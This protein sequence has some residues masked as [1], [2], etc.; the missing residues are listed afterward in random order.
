MTTTNHVIDSLSLNLA[1]ASILDSY[2]KGMGKT[3]DLE[4]GWKLSNEI[5]I[6]DF[7]HDSGA[8]EL[9]FHLLNE[10]LSIQ[11]YAHCIALLTVELNKSK[12]SAEYLQHVSKGRLSLKHGDASKPSLL[13]EFKTKQLLNEGTLA[14]VVAITKSIKSSA[15]RFYEFE[16]ASTD[17]TLVYSDLVY[18]GYTNISKLSS[19]LDD[20][21]LRAEM[22]VQD[23]KLL[24]GE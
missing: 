9:R 20:V 17:I 3:A 1:V 6:V 4:K 5:N 16:C 11:S 15:S 10:S 24:Q 18:L 7:N 13:E 12:P 21:G 19:G 2:N 22:T 8:C 23:F 14:K